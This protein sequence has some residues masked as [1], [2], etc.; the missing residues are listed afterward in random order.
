MKISL[1]LILLQLLLLILLLL[2]FMQ[3][4]IRTQ[5]AGLGVKGSNYGASA[6]DTYKEKVKKMVRK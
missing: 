1:V 4:K 2:S 3:A 5:N 6:T